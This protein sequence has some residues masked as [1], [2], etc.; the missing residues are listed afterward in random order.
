MLYYI[1][2]LLQSTEKC[3]H[4]KIFSPPDR[5]SILCPKY[6]KIENFDPKKPIH[7]PANLLPRL[8]KMQED[9]VLE[10]KESL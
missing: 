10:N 8:Y 1:L 6:P 7:M 9:F 4:F 3:I 5:R 2:F